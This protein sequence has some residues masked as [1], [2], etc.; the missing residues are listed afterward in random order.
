MRWGGWLATAAMGI[1]D[2]VMLATLPGQL[3]G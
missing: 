3:S 1:A 2:V